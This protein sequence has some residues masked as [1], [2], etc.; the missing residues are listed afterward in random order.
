MNGRLEAEVFRKQLEVACL[1]AHNLRAQMEANGIDHSVVPV[2]QPSNWDN[3]NLE[4]SSDRQ[5][6]CFLT[7][8]N[9]NGFSFLTIKGCWS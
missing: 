2:F 4:S 1:Q 7:Y 5:N 8:S 3:M 6:I 9:V